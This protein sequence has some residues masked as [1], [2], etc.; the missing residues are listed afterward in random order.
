MGWERLLLIRRRARNAA[1]EV[2]ERR[3]GYGRELTGQL[4]AAPG[5]VVSAHQRAPQAESAKCTGNSSHD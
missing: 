1:D 2:D 4:E 3:A 5:I